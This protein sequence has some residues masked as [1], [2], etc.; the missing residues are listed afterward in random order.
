MRGKR[1]SLES[2]LRYAS[3]LALVTHL[4][5]RGLSSIGDIKKNCRWI[6]PQNGS[7]QADNRL[8]GI[9]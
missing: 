4:V 9:Q 5:I 6:W 7:A 3:L 8:L 2:N 1:T